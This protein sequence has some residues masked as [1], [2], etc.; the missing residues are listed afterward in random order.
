MEWYIVLWETSQS[1]TAQGLPCETEG[2]IYTYLQGPKQNSVTNSFMWDYSQPVQSY[3]N[4]AHDTMCSVFWKV[5]LR[6]DTQDLHFTDIWSL[7]AWQLCHIWNISDS[8]T[9]ICLTLVL[10]TRH[11]LW[12]LL[13]IGPWTRWALVIQYRFF[14]LFL[15]I[16]WNIWP[17]ITNNWAPPLLEWP[18]LFL[19]ICGS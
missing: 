14:Y 7:G 12:Q 2:Q 16:Y 18:G 6:L 1:I 13:E 17:S 5:A 8:C 19:L 11:L 4:L 15:I 10:T 3:Q 9:H